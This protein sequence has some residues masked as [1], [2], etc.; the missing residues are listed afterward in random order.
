MH[1]GPGVGRAGPTIS[2]PDAG[3]IRVESAGFFGSPDND[4]CRRFLQAAMQTPAIDAAV[5]APGRA[6]SVDLHFNVKRH[7]RK[8]VLDRLA[9]RDWRGVVRYH[10]F[11]GRITGWRVERARVGS[12]RLTNPVLYR[13]RVLCEAIE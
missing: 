1:A 11:A 3:V 9:A 4:F 8:S 12:A 6:P 13:K 5:I 7:R 10:R 2:F